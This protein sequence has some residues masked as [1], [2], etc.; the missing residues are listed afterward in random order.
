MLRRPHSHGVGGIPDDVALTTLAVD[1]APRQIGNLGRRLGIVEKVDRD[2]EALV[3]YEDDLRT[4]DAA[5]IDGRLVDA[6][7]LQPI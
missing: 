1:P 7:Y 6:V 3:V 4:G 2:D 5:D